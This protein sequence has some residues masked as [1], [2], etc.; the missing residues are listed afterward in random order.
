MT[1]ITKKNT[2]IEIL[3]EAGLAGERSEVAKYSEAKW[4]QVHLNYNQTKV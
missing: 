2:E 4:E 1:E 3:L